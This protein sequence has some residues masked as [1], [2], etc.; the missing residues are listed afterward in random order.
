MKK[1]FKIVFIILGSIFLFLIVAG[2]YLYFSGTL[3]GLGLFV[4]YAEYDDTQNLPT[5]A[6][7]EN[8]ALSD[9][10]EKALRA[11]G[12]DPATVPSTITPEQEACFVEK[13]GQV[14]VD[15][16]IAGDSPTPYELLKGKSCLE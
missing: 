11:I 14:R 7:D 2:A 10:Q 5:K 3:A 9:T 13:F 8:P 15:E 6:E 12:I 1:F 16:I 4:N